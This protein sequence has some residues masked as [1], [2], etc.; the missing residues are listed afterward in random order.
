MRKSSSPEMSYASW[1]SIVSIL[2]SSKSLLDPLSENSVVGWLF[3]DD[4]LNNL[5]QPL[6][7]GGAWSFADDLDEV[8]N[9]VLEGWSSSWEVFSV[10]S[11]TGTLGVLFVPS[12]HVVPGKG[13]SD[14][15]LRGWL[16]LSLWSIVWVN[17]LSWSGWSPWWS[18]SRF[19]WSL[20]WFLLFRWSLWLWWSWLWFWASG[21]V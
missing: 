13:V 12:S 5:V 19:E 11:N 10:P 21:L 6:V 16:W 8:V 1:N 2:S 7:S 17:W 3:L 4:T 15:F 18:W 20:V 14:W 9:H